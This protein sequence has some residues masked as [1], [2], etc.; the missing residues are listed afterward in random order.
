MT[1]FVSLFYVTFD[2]GVLSNRV[3]QRLQSQIK[4]VY[5]SFSKVHR[6][7]SACLKWMEKLFNP[8]TKNTAGSCRIGAVDC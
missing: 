5:I 3:D 7:M 1:I 6:G 8:K 4:L 2:I